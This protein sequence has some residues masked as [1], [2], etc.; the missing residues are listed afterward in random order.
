MPKSRP[1]TV[2]GRLHKRL[3]QITCQPV[4]SCFLIR[5]HSSRLR[6]CHPWTLDSG[7]HD[8]ND[9]VFL[10]LALVYNDERSCL[11]VLREAGAS[12]TPFPSRSSRRYTQVL[13]TRL[14]GRDAEIQRP[15]MAN[16]GAQQMPLYPRT[17]K[18]GLASLLNQALV[19]R[20]VT[21]RGLDFGIPAEMTDFLAWPDLCITARAGAWER[22]NS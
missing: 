8:R 18:Q 7:I 13:E 9:G 1:W 4:V 17:G 12:K 10:T 21:V 16:W 3:I 22:A 2:S 5:G 15:R 14:F 11:A 6:V 20:L 19:Q